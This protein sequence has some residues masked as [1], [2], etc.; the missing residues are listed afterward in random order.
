MRYASGHPDSGANDMNLIPN[1]LRGYDRAAL[2]RGCLYVAV[3]E[4]HSHGTVTLASRDPGA[5][6]VVDL[7]MLTDE[8]DFAPAP[9]RRA[10]APRGRGVR[11]VPAHHTV[12]RSPPRTTGRSTTGCCETCTDHQHPAGTCRMGDPA[13]E[14]TVV[15]PRAACS[16]S[17]GC[18]SWTPP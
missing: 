3:Y 15:D 9:R 2:A 16:A 13:D 12:P 17:T 8:R 7:Q 10:T 11:T 14:R 18:A 1:T 6:P 4:S 5:H